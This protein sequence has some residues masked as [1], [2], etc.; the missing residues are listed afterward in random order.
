MSKSNSGFSFGVPPE[1][2]N[3]AD[4]DVDA[5]EVSGEPVTRSE[6][7]NLGFSHVDSGRGMRATGAMHKPDPLPADIPPEL[8]KKLE[9]AWQHLKRNEIEEAL[10]LAQEAVWES[11]TLVPAKI[12]I[13]RCFMNRKEYPKALNILQAVDASDLT[14]ETQYYIALCHSRLGRIKEGIDALKK[15]KGMPADPA[16]RKRINDLQLQLQG[17]QVVC[18]ICGK[19]ALYDSMVEV[20]D[21]T[22]CANCAKN[23]PEE[24]E[25]EDDEEWDEDAP[26]GKRRKRLR[27]PRTR[28]DI[29]LRILLVFFIIALLGMGLWAMSFVA[30]EYY[31]EIRPYLPE[32]WTF[33]P[34]PGN[35]TS[36][37]QIY[38]M[39]VQAQ[40]HQPS[41]AFD[42]PPI[43]HALAGVELRH[44]V[45]IQGMEKREGVFTAT[46]T[47]KPAGP[48]QFNEKTGEL[49]W[50]P[51]K[52]DAG[53]KFD[54]T[55]GATFT[56]VRA[57]EQVNS[58]TVGA[59]PRFRSVHSLGEPKPGTIL[60]LLSVDLNDDGDQEIIAVQGQY[61]E[62]QI[63]AI[64]ETAEGFFEPLSRTTLPGR[65]AGAGV[66]MAE[67]ET[68]LAVADYWNS[69]L[70]HYALRDGNLSEMAVD[71]D[72]PGRPLLAEFDKDSSTSAILCR[73]PDHLELVCY[74]QNGQ[75]QIN[76]LGQWPLSDEFVWR[77]LLIVPG[78]A[79][80]KR[81][82][83]PL[84]VGGDPAA[85]IMQVDLANNTLTPLEL[86]VQG[87]IINA[88]VG[89]D[90]RVY[91]LVK[92]PERLSLVGFSPSPSGKAEN[93]V[94]INA[95][96][97]PA[98]GGITDVRFYSKND[99]GDLALF[100]LGRVGV[101]FSRDGGRFSDVN[102]WN[103]PTPFR[104][105]GPAISVPASRNQPARVFYADEA[106]DMWRMSM[107]EAA[108]GKK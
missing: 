6:A 20:G 74:R 41:L 90:G 50:T 93:V 9:A 7:R 39:N 92:S 3:D 2:D 24:E 77:K 72:L 89:R 96:E 57:R 16:T 49:V 108:E 48:H 56:N 83:L 40:R 87:E 101:A 30:P 64:E 55:F 106:G 78:D 13:A 28:A 69:R 21:Q 26:G 76:K 10:T 84:L 68:W 62:G 5:V 70:R 82:P 91:C 35:A 71:V 104:L 63:V 61:W 66:V 32:S 103:L 33:L 15:A 73:F 81:E 67:N 38:D 31:K 43:D 94:T 85:S 4:M 52:Q 17:E 47:P 53:K 54:I 105:L 22:V 100:S 25:L 80:K 102:W 88:S 42:S 1:Q 12:I 37:S 36:I 58:V 98:L 107:T 18:P 79:E 23:M 14:A 8:S 51:G 27:P 44:R 97:T 34:P 86:E 11:P 19:K 60:H 45:F 75:L 65:P 59:G 99:A 29:L 46:F 95:G